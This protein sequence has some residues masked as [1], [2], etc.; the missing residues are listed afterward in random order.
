MMTHKS[1]PQF[2]V[3]GSPFRLASHFLTGGHFRS[4][5]LLSSFILTQAL[6]VSAQI[7]APSATK[8]PEMTP[9]KLLEVKVTGSHRFAAEQIAAASGL[10]VGAT[11]VEE[12]FRKAARQLGETGAF[13]NIS[14][15]YAYSSAG[16]KLAFQVADADK[17]VPAHFADLV[18]FSDQ[19]L[20]EKIHERVPLFTGELPPTGRLPD[21]VS[22]VLQAVLVENN[23][24]GHVEY[25]RRADK[26]DQ[27]ESIDYTVSNVSIRVRQVEFNGVAPAE[28]QQLKTAA[29]QLADREYSRGLLTGFIEHTVL[30]IYHERGYLK[31]TCAPPQPKVVK[32]EALKPSGSE[33][34]DSRG[35]RTIVDIE[36]AVT[37]GMQYKVAGWSWS[38]NKE[39]STDTLQPLIQAKI[40]LPANTVQLDADMKRV[41]ELYGTRGFVTATIKVNAQLDN[42]A[43]TTTYLL[44]V[45]EGPVYR[46][47]ELAFRGIDNNLEARLR[48]AWKIRAGDVYDAT[49]LQQYLP[50]ARKLL[51]ANV[52]WEVSSHVTAIT[53][54]KTVDVD[55]QYMAKALR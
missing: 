18:W 38:G 42:A 39:I 19:E 34:G 14:F 54:E 24:P 37:P 4:F 12:D 1:S 29:E 8:G 21:Q 43:S 35:N 31:A 30:P 48:A 7:Q 13:S 6:I 41:Q 23:I 44:E 51:P 55:L 3:L 15:T 49:Y 52:D 27:L 2:P 16:T 33:A 17:F 11:V 9:S 5:C 53:R 10:P 47:G 45:N 32:P 36:L 20:L 50:Q 22:D 46:M 26:S 28:L 40:G 25:L